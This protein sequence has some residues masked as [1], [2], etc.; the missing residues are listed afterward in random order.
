MVFGYTKNVSVPLYPWVYL[1][2]LVAV[3][4]KFYSLVRLLD[5]SSP[6]APCIEPSDTVRANPQERGFQVSY[7]WSLLSPVSKVCSVFSNSFKSR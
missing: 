1:S 7:N 2:T 3:V 5:Y 4:H 6:L